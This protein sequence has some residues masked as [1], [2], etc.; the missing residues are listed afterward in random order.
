[1]TPHGTK[2]SAIRI[3]EAGDGDGDLENDGEAMLICGAR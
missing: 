3:V 1:M 2:Q